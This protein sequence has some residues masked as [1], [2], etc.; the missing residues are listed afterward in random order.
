MVTS[1]RPSSP[2]QRLARQTRERFVVALDGS[3]VEL[4]AQAQAQLAD[5]VN[6]GLKAASVSEMQLA[7]D[8]ARLFQS[9]RQ[10]WVAT[11]RKTWR[12]SL[13]QSTGSGLAPGKPGSFQLVDD[14][15]VERK[16]LASRLAAGVSEAAGTEIN[17]LKLR[18][19]RLERSTDWPSQDVLRPETLSMVL[20]KAW[21]DCGLSPAMWQLVQ[22]SIQSALTR[23]MVDAYRAANAYLVENG[24]MA[25]I[26]LKALVRRDRQGSGWGP[27]SS[28]VPPSPPAQ[29]RMDQPLSR[30]GQAPSRMGQASTRM[31]DTMR[32]GPSTE[33]PYV[34]HSA[35]ARAAS[36]TRM[37]TGVSPMGRIRERAQGVLGQL[38]RMLSDH[39]AGFDPGAT[40]SPP[41]PQLARALAEPNMQ[42]AV[43]ELMD[44]AGGDLTGD[45]PLTSVDAVAHQLRRRANELKAKAEKPN[46]KAIIEIV[47]LMFQAILAEERIPAALRVWFA[48]LQIPVLRLALAEP[49]FFASVQHPA[50]Q[51]I[52]RMGACALG[53]D[54][55]QIG[56]SRLEREIKRIV[57][58]IEQYPETGRRVYQLV[59]LTSSRN[60]WAA[61]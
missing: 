41:S 38:R 56:G 54:A 43:T 36:E 10:N 29:T 3:V 7:M 4:M 37:M 18:V 33:T 28:P 61:P 59:F 25:E 14:T 16:I 48:R 19:Q 55:A 32:G 52:D 47:A 11:V 23:R 8:A 12:E 51:L 39:V 5:L 30:M 31:G 45:V 15:V 24:V 49:D 13:D 9:Q 42:F 35:L 22:P 53:F 21:D 44:R 17:D 46:E 50:R 40:V 6:G 20:V 57:Q 26:D 58:V 1:S 60:S 34:R 2:E 27:A